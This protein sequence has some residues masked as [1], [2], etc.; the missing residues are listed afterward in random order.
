MGYPRDIQF[1]TGAIRPDQY[2]QERLPEVAFAGRSNVGKSSLIN[3]VVG[4]KGLARTSQTPGKTQLIHFY[5]VEGDFVLVDLPGYG[6]A[7]VPEAIRRRWGPM[8]E[9]YLSGRKTL[10]L[11]VLIL[12]MRRIPSQ[13]DRQLKSWLEQKALS[14]CYVLTKAD[15]IPR[16]KRSHK[17]R[18]I[19]QT[20]GASTE[21]LLAFSARTREG[22]RAL[23]GAIR[24]AVDEYR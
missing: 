23:W 17:I 20:L 16:G 15:K 10:C 22:R 13:Q 4:R 11:V 5:K 2:P 24:R 21:E 1:L 8:V 14:T 12:D 19:A 3:T 9:R 7:R 6:Y 18:Q